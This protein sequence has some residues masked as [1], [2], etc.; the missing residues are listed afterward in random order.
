MT[1]IQRIRKTLRDPMFIEQL[2]LVAV[3]VL[4]IVMIIKTR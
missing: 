2:V 1:T 3:V 4:G